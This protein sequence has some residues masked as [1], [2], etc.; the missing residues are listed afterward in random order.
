MNAAEYNRSKA[1]EHDALRA[2]GL[3]PF[4]AKA[5]T[6]AEAEEIAAWQEAHGIAA[7]GKCGPASWEALR[8]TAAIPIGYAG[9][10]AAYGDP[11]ERPS[12]NGRLTVDDA[13]EKANMRKV[14]LHDGR[15][16]TLHRAV[17]D[18]FRRAFEVACRISGYTPVSVQTYVPRCKLWNPDKPASLHTWGV[19]VDFDPSLNRM[20]RTAGTPIHN[21]PKFLAVF[22]VLGW[23]IGADWDMRDNMHIQRC[24]GC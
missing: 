23:S 12:K 17:A 20:G 3:W 18:E 4:K 16:V 7:D 6:D 22:R 24:K 14:K 15:T 13:W 9:V 8:S 2:L 10:R 11:R 1:T 5:G 19:A 21:H